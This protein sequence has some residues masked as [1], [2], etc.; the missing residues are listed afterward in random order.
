ML[1]L[2]MVLFC[3]PLTSLPIKENKKLGEKKKNNTKKSIFFLIFIY[4]FIYLIVFEFLFYFNRY[5]QT[6]RDSGFP[7]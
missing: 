7:V 4:L 1:I 3:L 2:F 6:P 5:P